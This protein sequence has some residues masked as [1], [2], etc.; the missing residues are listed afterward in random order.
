MA[1]IIEPGRM[2]MDSAPDR[3]RALPAR[4]SRFYLWAALACALVGI[5]G[6]MGT[7]WL[8]LPAGTFRGPPLLH[9][10]GALSTA[11]LIFVISQSSLVLR[12]RVRNHR[13]WG[14]FGIALASVLTIVALTVAV[15]AMN[16]RIA[17][18]FG[19]S[20]RSFLIVP[21]SAITLFAGF[22][23]AAIANVKRPDGTGVSSSLRQ[24]AWFR[25]RLRGCSF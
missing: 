18:G 10:H 1:T 4:R 2:E 24:A 22:T 20:A 15:S 21:L 23:A 14:L 5:G 6:F 16:D 13:E 12:G 3:A 19:D 9:I 25:R 8:Q 17:A 7:Y 11:W